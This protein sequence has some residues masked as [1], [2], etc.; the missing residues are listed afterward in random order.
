MKVKIGRGWFLLPLLLNCT[1]FYGFPP[2][3]EEEEMVF[4]GRIILDANVSGDR[5]VFVLHPKDGSF[6]DLY[7]VAGSDEVEPTCSE[8]NLILSSNRGGDYDLYD[9]LGNPI[10]VSEGNDLQPSLS[11]SGKYVIFVTQSLDVKG[12]LALYDLE[13]RTLQVWY[14]A[15]SV[16]HPSFVSD[17]EVILVKEDGIYLLDLDS[18]SYRRLVPATL[19][20]AYPKVNPSSDL[21]AYVEKG[22]SNRLVLVTF[23]GGSG[24]RILLTAREDLEG[25]AW[26]PEGDLLSVGMG[27]SI[28]VIDTLGNIYVVG[29]MPEV[30]VGCWEP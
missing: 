24:R 12:D 17:R 13:S 25:I 26:S 18:L 8:S 16:A 30:R 4:T 3:E 21:L 27:D 6:Q 23:P 28:L 15:T 20:I 29:E 10:Y 2:P 11:P 9:S 14:E 5:G 19:P 7:D 22:D 1:K